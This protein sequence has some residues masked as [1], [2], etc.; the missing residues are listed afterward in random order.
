MRNK[1]TED[2]YQTWEIRYLV[3]LISCQATEVIYRM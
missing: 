3:L 1:V 2:E